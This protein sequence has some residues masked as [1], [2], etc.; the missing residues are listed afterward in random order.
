MEV[1]DRL[2]MFDVEKLYELLVDIHRIRDQTKA[3]IY[4]LFGEKKRKVKING[5]LLIANI[6][7]LIK[8]LS[9][10]AFPYQLYSHTKETI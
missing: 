8:E 6:E 4:K 5:Y 1:K 2:D 9:N 7:S 3:S 10:A